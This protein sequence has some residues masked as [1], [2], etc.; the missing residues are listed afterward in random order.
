MLYIKF[1]WMRMNGHVNFTAKN[2]EYGLYRSYLHLIDTTDI[3]Y[4]EYWANFANKVHYTSLHDYN[5]YIVH[6]FQP[7]TDTF[8][9]LQL[10]S[11]PIFTN[12]STCRSLQTQNTQYCIV[13]NYKLRRLIY[14]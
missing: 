10:K 3:Y 9:L 4:I 14:N 7:S 8:K 1:V 11:S 2:K 5:F 12:C 13:F 6:M